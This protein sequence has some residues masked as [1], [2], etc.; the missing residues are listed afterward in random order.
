LSPP[1][2][3]LPPLSEIIAVHA[4]PAERR[5]AVRRYA[6]I[7]A[8][9]LA[10]LGVSLNL[11]PVIDLNH[12]IIRPDDRYTRIYRRA[13]SADPDIV[14]DVAAEYCATL[15]G[16]RVHCTLKHF[17]GLGRVAGD[18]H[19][20][21]A[22]LEAPMDELARTDWVPFRAMM[23][24]DAVTMVGHARLVAV[25]RNRPA[26]LSPV[27]IG[28]L[29]REEWSYGGVL[30]TDDVTMAAAWD[31]REGGPDG[32]VTA[33]NAGMDLILVSYDPDQ[34]YPVIA[35]LLEA[36]REGRL[37]PDALERS[38]R[39]LSRIAGGELR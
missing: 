13:I 30:I 39:R 1:L 37:R 14:A 32:I 12:H 21:G 27:V 11:A 16:R 36:A 2:E 8:Q 18:T 33:I 38:D 31:S 26:S 4:D 3:R 7:Q 25:D 20:A 10:D 22:D 23:N 24:D 34:I 28:G 17:P 5:A 6:G 19:S 15:W 9:G 29:L 35:A